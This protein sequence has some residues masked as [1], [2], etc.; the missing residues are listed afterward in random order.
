MSDEGWG[1]P[2]S[3]EIRKM[4]MEMY[5]ARDKLAELKRAEPPEQV[6]T[7]Y[8]FDSPDGPVRL[9][10]LFGDHADLVLVHNMGRGC[11]YC[12]MW[13]DGFQG[14]YAHLA[15]RCA[16]VVASPDEV[17]AQ[18][19]FAASRGWTFPMVSCRDTPFTEDMRFGKGNEVFP[20]CS[21]FHKDADG[22]ITRVASTPFGPMDQ[23][24]A[25]WQLFALLKDGP[26][27]WQ[28]R[29]SYDD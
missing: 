9:S 2:V 14:L 8:T 11:S 12:T 10:Q 7:D 5:A 16:F 6:P 19:A 24:N 23:F 4:E 28:P 17:E 27:D 26:G 1:K 29:L 20:G 18:Q 15:D 3:D 21:T 25:G 22:A 13:A